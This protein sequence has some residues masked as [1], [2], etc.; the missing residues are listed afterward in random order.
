LPSESNDQVQSIVTAIGDLS[1]AD[2]EQ[3]FSQLRRRPS[4]EL[5]GYHLAPAALNERIRVL[6]RELIDGYAALVRRLWPLADR[7][8]RM[9]RQPSEQSKELQRLHD[10]EDKSYAELADPFDMSREAVRQ[11]VG[12]ARKRR[13]A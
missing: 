10:D 3:L 2:R 11:A 13:T 12:R 9:E 6:T 8:R 1:G 4:T 7:A 5:G